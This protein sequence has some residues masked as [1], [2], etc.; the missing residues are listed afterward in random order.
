MATDVVMPQMGESIAEGTIVRWIKQVGDTVERDDPLVEI[1]TDKVD[2]E[3]PSPAAGV[4]TE[5]RAKEG[6]T[7]EVNTVLA[8]IGEPGAKPAAA[9]RQATVPAAAAHG[10]AYTPAPPTTAAPAPPAPAAVSAPS[11]APDALP[12]PAAAPATTGPA[13]RLQRSS[14][15]VRRIA[16]EHNV[17]IGQIQGTGISGRV[18]KHDILSFL[19]KGSTE[20]APASQTSSGQ[21]NVA[22]PSAAPAASRPSAQPAKPA[23]PA[24]SGSAATGAGLAGQVVP[25]S[26]MRRKIAEHMVKSR[27]T[28]AHVHSVF[29]VNFAQVDKIRQEKKADY[30]RAGT[31]LTYLSFIVMAVVDALHAIPVMNASVDGDNII[32]HKQV[33]IGIAVALDWGLIVPVIKDADEKNLLGLSRTVVDLAA[34]ARNRQL[35]PEDVNGG[36]F[37]ITNPGV[38]G[39]LFGM[40]IINQPQVGILG[41]GAVEK[42]AIVIDDAIAIRPMAY[43]AIGYDH[44]IID[45]AV[46]DEFMSHV[47]HRLEH[48]DPSEA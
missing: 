30:E 35:K 10:E 37:T 12:V 33:N 22:P 40:P 1:S 4:I 13:D 19:E 3:I 42:R 26:V 24:P 32:Y 31:K 20:A 11:S 15:L 29:E 21:P 27:H 7:V 9:A 25:M 41:V 18:T 17:D 8:V 14:P 45:G 43:L 48:W 2:T 23:A 46:A 38:F 16:K 34:R 47:K 6:E 5:I 39:A 36:T 44:R 28:S